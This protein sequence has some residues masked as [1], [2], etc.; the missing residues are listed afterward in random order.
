MS[1]HRNEYS[2]PNFQQLFENSPGLYLVLLPNLKIAG[3]SKAYLRATFT[4]REQLLG[5]DIFEIFPDNPDYREAD[6]EQNLRASLL[7]VLET[8]Q[9]DE[10]PIQRYDVR[11]PA[12]EGGTFVE[13][14]WRP[15][16]IPILDPNGCVSYILH[17]VEDVTE[18]MLLKR[19]SQEG[20]RLVEEIRDYAIFALDADGRVSTWNKGARRIIGY[21]ASEIIGKPLSTF[22]P[23]E[24]IQA[25]KAESELRRAAEIGRVEDEGWRIRK[26]GSRFWA[27][28]IVTAIR[29]EQGNLMGFSKITRDITERKAAEDALRDSYKELEQRV[30]ERTAELKKNNDELNES[31]MRYEGLVNS[32]DGIVWESHVGISPYTFVSPQAEKMLGY[33]LKRWLTESGFWQRIIHPDDQRR[34]VGDGYQTPEDRANSANEYRVIAANG[35]TIWVRDIVTIAYEGGVP[36]KLCGIMIDCTERKLVEEKM[37]AARESALKAARVKADFVANISHEIRTPLNA[38][39]GMATLVLDT[40]LNR[41]QRD[42]IQTIKRSA[43]ILLALIN[44][45]LDFSKIDAGKLKLEILD[46]TLKELISEAMG[47]VA[48][49]A[50][51]KKLRLAMKIEKDVPKALVGDPGRLLQ[52]LTNLLSNAI[53]FTNE[54]TV[55]VKVRKQQDKTRGEGVLFEVEDSGIGIPEQIRAQLFNPFSQGDP[56]MARRYGGT[57][58]GLSICKRLAELMNGEIGVESTPGK[59]STFWFRIPLVEAPRRGAPQVRSTKKSLLQSRSGKRRKSGAR[60]LVAEDNAANQKLLLLFLEKLGYRAD[61]VGNGLEALKALE[62]IPYDLILMDCQM[63]EMDGYEATRKIRDRERLLSMRRIPILALTAHALGG[64]REKCVQAGMDD[65]ISKPIDFG[66]LQRILQEVEEKVSSS[67]SAPV[68][69]LVTNV[70]ADAI[71]DASPLLELA[72]FDSLEQFQ[73][74]GKPDIVREVIETFMRVSGSRMRA[75]SD[76]IERQ[77]SAALAK[78]AHEFVSTASTVGARRLTSACQR[79]EKDVENALSLEALRSKVEEISII[80]GK[81]EDELSKILLRRERAVA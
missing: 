81:T 4:Q 15:L 3:A 20:Q 7:K 53:K 31:R 58:L 28:V 52:I 55:F 13:R 35:K 26:D 54:G 37:I 30:I 24:D 14:Y 34:F 56:S 45:V 12:S 69:K 78:L 48:L 2:Q 57:G 47:L 27:N 10:M 49:T 79:L 80:C 73:M 44:D 75:M 33:P 66:R 21:E 11:M 60:I 40:K 9:P 18:T 76:A 43:G 42:Y 59:G 65:Y 17:T 38:V 70:A 41:A 51:Q 63:P 16:N 46:F 22:Y 62:N 8:K 74:P 64:D 32:I 71:S 72:H 5:K 68:L 25:G 39:I 50:R 29:D 1:D 61:A 23:L 67:Q 6:G 77:D 36:K 19:A